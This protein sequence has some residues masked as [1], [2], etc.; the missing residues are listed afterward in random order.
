MSSYRGRPQPPDLDDRTWQDLVDEATELIGHYAPQWTDR[1]PSDP[2]MAVIELF[3][4]LVE[5]LLYRLNR[6]PEKNYLAFL[7]LLGIT[8][9]PAT[10]ARTLLTF[11]AQ[12]G[13]SAA[14]PEGAWAQTGGAESQAP[15]VFQTESELLALPAGLS[16]VVRYD[17]PPA[18]AAATCAEVIGTGAELRVPDGGTSF[19]LLGLDPAFTQPVE[20]VE[21]YA[22]P[23]HPPAGETAALG[24][25]FSSGGADPAGWAVLTP[26]LDTG[27]G[28]A[29]AGQIRLPLPAAWPAVDP[30]NWPFPPGGRPQAGR[31]R[32]WIGLRLRNEQ[33]PGE[34]ARD[35]LVQVRHL[36]PSTVPATT[37][38]TA[39]RD[40]PEALGT[41]GRAPRQVYELRNRPVYSRPG[42]SPYDHVKIM[43]D[44]VEW[45][46]AEEREQGRDEAVRLDPVTGEIVFG[47]VGATPPPGAAITAVYRHVA[48]GAAGNVLPATVTTLAEGVPGIVSVT[49]RV[50]GTDGVDEEPIE[51]TKARAPLLLRTRD[52]AI[53]AEDYEF[54]AMRV[55]GVAIARCLAPRAQDKAGPNGAWLAGDPWT[56]G[57][58]IRAPGQ[59]NLIVVPD[60][61]TD[62]A[63]P[64][65]PVALVQD[66][67]A[68]LDRCREVTADL[69]VTG[70]RY[71]PIE[72]TADVRVFK[73]AR[74]MHL[75]SG[76]AE[77]K[78]QIKQ[79]VAA[80]L[81]PV[82][83]GPGG[84][85]W[86]V[87]QSLYLP[88]VYQAVRPRDDIGY[89][90]DLRLRPATPPPYHAPPIG[91]GGE[92]RGDTHR[93]FPLPSAF[94]PQVKVADYE[95]ICF[96]GSCEVTGE[97]E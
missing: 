8:R 20:R 13:Q 42:G 21:L 32:R 66:V 43:V 1:S 19:L 39:G 68:A 23:D 64:E 91:P 27:H 35:A 88:D 17:V 16:M 75:T 33:E 86:Q 40:A 72:V 95:L 63:R 26:E 57:S 71:L 53:T 45:P 31:P 38:L 58:L 47:D 61:G 96:S 78:E 11:T 50:H 2:G 6:V 55:P 14:V 24:W 59:V 46:L 85:G 82:R 89:L 49:N 77:V 83:G 60:F 65:P 52:R 51:E 79:R 7:N 69:T 93:P 73:R 97:E 87:G 15:V 90:A 34:P 84:N 54:L 22:E 4:W 12:T 48:A 28:L 67:I 76:L 36:L 92:W 62:D 94:A 29:R 5:G 18:P 25:V 81:H 70:P 74:D 3:A 10:P 80:F 37:A 30:A 9:A 56:F 44:G 41:A